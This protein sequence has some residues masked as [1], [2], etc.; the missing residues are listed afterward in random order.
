MNKLLQWMAGA[1]WAIQPEA[2]GRFTRA[3]M[4]FEP[5]DM[6]VSKE[7]MAQHRLDIEAAAQVQVTG[8]GIAIIPIMGVLSQRE[9][10]FSFL[11]G[12]STTEGIARALRQSVA[13]P[14]VGAIVLDIDSPGGNVFGIPELAMEILAARGSKPIVA[15]VNSLAASAAYWLAVSATEVVVTPSG[16]VGS[17]GVVTVH[18]D[19]TAM[20]EAEGVKITVISA[21]KFKTEGHPFEPLTDEA[22]ADMQGKL[23]TVH[24]M[25]IRAVA[26]GRGVNPSKI[27][28]GFGEG[29][30][31]LAAEAVKLGMADR[32]DTLAG[33]LARLAGGRRGR[34]GANASAPESITLAEDQVGVDTEFQRAAAEAQAGFDKL[35][36]EGQ[37]E[38][39]D[40]MADMETV[41]DDEAATDTALSLAAARQRHRD[42]I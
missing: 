29:R 7:N 42:R 39:D 25:F 35:T 1:L 32:V 19:L 28:G 14:S 17:I 20:A 36:A 13:D 23:D 30:V 31:V 6:E 33:T 12:G 27:R 5:I 34:R 21:G 26:K 15:V 37:A 10:I 9:S 16:A 22:R 4:A 2:L 24:D 11:F 40:I 18:E 3:A 38:L 41:I 8:G